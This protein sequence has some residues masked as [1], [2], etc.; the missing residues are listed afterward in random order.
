MNA[1]G[2]A[3]EAAELRMAISAALV[4]LY[5]AFYGHDPFYVHDRVTAGTSINDKV[6][7]S[8]PE[9][10]LPQGEAGLVRAVASS[11]SVDRRVAFETGDDDQFCAAVERLARRRVVAFM[12]HGQTASGG[13]C[14]LFSYGAAPLASGRRAP[15]VDTMNR[16]PTTL[17]VPTRRPHLSS[18]AS[19]GDAS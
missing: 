19:G 16:S 12:S 3:A 4:E 18:A 13:A 11:A 7:V 14:V 8:V 5:T 10:S 2:Q 1:A 17:T 6:V 15:P 9:S